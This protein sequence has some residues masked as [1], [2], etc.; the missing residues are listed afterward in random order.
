MGTRVAYCCALLGALLL[1]RN[2]QTMFLGLP[3]EI[4]Q[5]AIY[6]LLFFHVPAWWSAFLAVGVS[7]LASLAYIATKKLKW[8]AIA[9][10]STEV[11]LVF[12]ITGLTLG[13]I[14]GRII[15]GIWWTWD[16]RLTSSLALVLLYASYLALR[17][18]IDEP[19]M[20]A[21]ISGV[22]SLFCFC[23]VPI[24]WFSI[25]WWRTQHP[26]PMDL[27]PDMMKTLLL[28]WL[29]MLLL[30]TALILIRLGQEE[31]LRQL[32]A[33]RQEVHGRDSA[34]LRSSR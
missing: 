31:A 34:T 11:G 15:W 21:R 10:A 12:L 17:R 22:Y 23:D 29:A 13:S 7:F 9:V 3:D 2:L 33:M 1:V 24:V 27:P 8:D 18:S 32:A 4:S 19:T 14:W 20:R 28:N 25:R 30:T 16:P 26:P 6:R 5:G